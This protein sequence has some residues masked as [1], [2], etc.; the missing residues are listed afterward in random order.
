MD[1]RVSSRTGGYT[2]WLSAGLNK[3]RYLPQYLQEAGYNTYYAGKFLVEYA[4]YNKN[5]VPEGA[6]LMAW[7]PV[8]CIPIS[9]G[10]KEATSRGLDRDFRKRCVVSAG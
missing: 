2:K 8:A 9:Q 4:L 7:P 10:T 5:P 3:G 1:G 6:L